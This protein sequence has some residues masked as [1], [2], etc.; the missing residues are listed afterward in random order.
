MANGADMLGERYAEE[1][2]YKIKQFPADWEKLK[3]SAGPIRNRQMAE[4]ADACVVFWDGITTGSKNMIKTA[5]EKG[6]L[7]KVINYTEVKNKPGTHKTYNIKD[8]PEGAKVLYQKI[9]RNGIVD[10]SVPTYDVL[11]SNEKLVY[12]FQP[13]K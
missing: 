2:R 11:K 5:K 3:K 4:Y 7:L 10:L 6:L 12:F 13:N 1:K 9:E 8:I